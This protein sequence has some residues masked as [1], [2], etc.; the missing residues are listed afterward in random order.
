M[1][2]IWATGALITGLITIAGIAS[3]VFKVCWADAEKQ[4]ADKITTNNFFM[5]G[6]GFIPVKVVCMKIK[7]CYQAG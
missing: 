6:T 1:R 5:L 7:P 4:Q 2:F 3:P